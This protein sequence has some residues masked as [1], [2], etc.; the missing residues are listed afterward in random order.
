MK[1]TIISIIIAGAVIAGAIWLA[2]GGDK[3]ASVDNV[4]LV[5]GQQIIEIK[6]KGGY[7]PRLTEAQAG[8]PTILKIKTTGTFDCSSALTIPELK[9]RFSLP[10][11]G[12]TLVEV[13]PQVAGST[14]EGLCS[15]GMYNFQIRFN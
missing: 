5:N 10:L 1:A 3:T 7:S 11:S 12:E 9:Y 2:G 8:V 4:S 13:P 14:L 15:M 6:A